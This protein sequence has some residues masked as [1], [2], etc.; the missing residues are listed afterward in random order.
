MRDYYCTYYW[1]AVS[2][3]QRRCQHVLVS[4]QGAA[5]CSVAVGSSRFYYADVLCGYI[6]CNS[7][8]P[9]ALPFELPK[10]PVDQTAWFLGVIEVSTLLLHPLLS[11]SEASVPP[12]EFL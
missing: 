4:C 7:S 6:L 8:S 11:L 5:C 2:C 10:G 12:Y 1:V 3:F 9:R